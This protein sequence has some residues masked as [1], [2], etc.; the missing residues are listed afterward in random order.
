[1][2]NRIILIMKKNIF[3]FLL[4]M[5]VTAMAQ[6]QT[7]IATFYDDKFEGRPTASGEAYSQSKA[8]AAHRSLPF[9]TMIKVTNLENKKS[10]I[11][12]VNDRGPFVDSRLIDLSKSAAQ[13]LGFVT[14][15]LARVTV[16][17]IDAKVPVKAQEVAKVDEKQVNFP[18]ELYELDI[19]FAQAK[20]FAIQVGS[21][22]ELS[23]LMRIAQEV[24]RVRG[25]NLLVQ[26]TDKDQ[27]KL[28]R[29]LVGPIGDRVQ[30]DK[31]KE[32]LKKSF[33]GCFVID[34]SK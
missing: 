14:A 11:V 29:L 32:Q 4:W 15:G 3:L 9:G 6:T 12:K 16:E 22:T 2:F 27:K 7:G 18:N 25:T 33:S 10:V 5:S 17:I 21:F 20:G 13:A 1:M 30:A 31:M 19:K 28:H 24:R 26:V 23:N 34:L 8:T